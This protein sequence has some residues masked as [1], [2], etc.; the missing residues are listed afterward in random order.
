[1][2]H[3][4]TGVPVHKTKEEFVESLKTVF[5][6]KFSSQPQVVACGPGRVNLIG[7]HTDYCGGF[8][9]PMAL[10]LK[11]VC[12]M[13]T[14][15]SGVYNIYSENMKE[16][17]TFKGALPTTPG[18]NHEWWNYV[19]GSMQCFYEHTKTPVDKGV[20]MV[21]GSSVPLG[22]GLSSSAAVEVAVATALESLHNLNLTQVEM[23]EGICQR[24][25]HVWAGMPCGLMDQAISIMGKQ[26]HAMLFDCMN[27]KATHATLS[28]DVKVVVVDSGV[29]HKLVD[30]EYGKRKAS[31]EEALKAL[32]TKYPSLTCL[33]EAKM[34][35]LDSVKSLMSDDTY[36]KA[37]HVIC[38]CQRCLDFCDVLNKGDY[39]EV[40]RLL[41]EAHWSLSKKYDVS[42]PQIDEIVNLAVKL[43][44]VIGARL[45]GGG[46]GGCVVVL[47]EAAKAEGVKTELLNQYTKY[48]ESSGKGKS[49]RS[50]ASFSEPKAYIVGAADGAHLYTA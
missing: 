25:E 28:A 2:V 24:A 29:R 37:S 5:T 19:V 44:G 7:E 11:C 23:A 30:G 12:L 42:A 41:S 39:K 10:D 33:R 9:F 22:G 13:A 36:T 8:V 16:M 21:V 27:K 32:K 43:P 35:Q 45:T 49:D 3:V 48:Y 47:C 26:N 18:K 31:C 15:D 17:Q 4:P 40:G 1:M 14:N 20:N 50:D 46:F 6:Q 38:E 34:D